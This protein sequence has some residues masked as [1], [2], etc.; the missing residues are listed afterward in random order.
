MQLSG[1]PNAQKVSIARR[2]GFVP[3]LPSHPLPPLHPSSLHGIEPLSHPAM[4]ATAPHGLG[5]IRAAF[6]STSPPRPRRL[7][8][9]RGLRRLLARLLGLGLGLGLLLLARQPNLFARQEVID[10]ALGERLILEQ[11][12][13]Q[14][15]QLLLVLPPHRGRKRGVRCAVEGWVAS[16]PRGVGVGRSV[17][18][19]VGGS[20]DGG[21]VGRW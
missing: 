3:R 19:W 9:S 7:P 21:C 15:M 10:L 8:T 20:C 5:S 18:R 12:L 1:A 17:G 6:A 14:P 16:R 2:Y 13:R 11:T 4:P